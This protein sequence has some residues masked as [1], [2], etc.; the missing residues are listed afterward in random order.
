MA[1][2][3]PQLICEGLGGNGFLI[4]A[5]LCLRIV[6]ETVLTFYGMSFKGHNSLH[7][8]MQPTCMALQRSDQVML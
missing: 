7:S 8:M 5:L 4:L 6:V 2:H 1:A 3:A